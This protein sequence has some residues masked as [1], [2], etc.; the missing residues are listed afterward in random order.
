MGLGIR[1]FL[2][3]GSLENREA[4]ETKAKSKKEHSHLTPESNS[5]SSVGESVFVFFK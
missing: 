2:C 3:L 4:K 1:I 5:E